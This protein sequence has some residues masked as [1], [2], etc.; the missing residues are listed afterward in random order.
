MSVSTARSAELPGLA[1]KPFAPFHRQ[2]RNFHLAYVALIWLGILAGFGPEVVTHIRTHAAPF[3]PIVHVHAVVFVGWLALFT[4]QILMVRT[5]RLEFHRRL[6]WAMVGVAAGMAVLGPLTALIADARHLGTPL[7]D[8]PFIA[9]Q[10]T[11][12]LAFVGLMIPAVLLRKDAATHKRLILL[13]TIYISDAGFA[14]F[15]GSAFGS[16]LGH[17]FWGF[18]AVAYLGPALLMVG[19]G[20]YDLA[21][22]GRLHPA[23]LAGVA[24][25]V[26]LQMTAVT[27]YHNAAW[28]AVAAALVKRF[29]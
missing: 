15:V 12:I 25:A 23:Y 6:G 5:R 22:R 11:D 14:R 10:F 4:T 26:A 18:W 28:S 29:A 3:P 16:V 27:L 17:G 8:P 21:T 24:Y 9:I 13:A 19:V 2:D 7:S 1:R 20:A